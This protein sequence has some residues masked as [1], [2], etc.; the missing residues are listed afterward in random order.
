[1]PGLNSRPGTYALILLAG[2]EQRIKVGSLDN[3]DVCP[4]FY[5]YTGSAFGSGG[6]VARSGVTSPEGSKR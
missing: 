6:L 5:V 3:L 4:G 1:M 2:T